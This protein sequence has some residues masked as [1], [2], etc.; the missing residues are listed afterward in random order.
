[1]SA[2]IQQQALT[3]A[4][5]RQGTMNYTAIFEGFIAKGIPAEQILP[6]VNVFTFH[7]WKALGRSVRKGEH[8]VRVVTFVPV[9]GKIDTTTGEV[10]NG[11][12]KPHTTTV[13]HVSQT[14]LTIERQRQE[15]HNVVRECEPCDVPLTDEQ[16]SAQWSKNVDAREWP[17]VQ[18]LGMF[19]GTN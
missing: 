11:Y 8:G 2:N 15:S 13:F 12:R 16:A 19:G 14:E 1:M 9:A 6:R 18:D 10:K 5:S 7:A 4:T 3:N 17:M